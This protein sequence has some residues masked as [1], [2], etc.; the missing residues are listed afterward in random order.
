MYKLVVD[1]YVII[2]WNKNISIED[3]GLPLDP[4]MT[5]MKHAVKAELVVEK[6]F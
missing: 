6:V 1:F 2:I 4:Y 5:L 3:M